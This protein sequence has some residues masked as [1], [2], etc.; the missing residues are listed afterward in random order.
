MLPKRV[1]SDLAASPLVWT[2]AP[3]T[4]ICPSVAPGPSTALEGLAVMKETTVA[5]PSAA[6]EVALLENLHP[7]LCTE[8]VGWVAG[9]KATIYSRV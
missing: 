8:G 9:V 3:G 5:A 6:A 1:S 7:G 4:I 2:A